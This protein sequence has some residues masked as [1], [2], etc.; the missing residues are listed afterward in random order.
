MNEATE[1]TDSWRF[2]RRFF[3]YD[4][5]SGIDKVNGYKNN[6]IPNVIR[7]ASTIKVKITL[8]P[9][10]EERIYTPYVEITYRE[11]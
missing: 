7:W 6:T 4:T 11:K 3:V 5:I 10:S 8:D 1:F 9:D 2:V